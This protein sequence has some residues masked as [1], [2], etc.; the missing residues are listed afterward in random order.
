MGPGPPPS[1]G[2]SPPDNQMWVTE[3]LQRAAHTQCMALIFCEYT[4]ELAEDPGKAQWAGKA[5]WSGKA[6]EFGHYGA[7]YPRWQ[8]LHPGLQDTGLVSESHLLGVCS[9][10]AALRM[11]PHRPGP[12]RA[13]GSAGELGTLSAGHRRYQVRALCGKSP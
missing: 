3:V 10:Q 2:F 1:L 4:S 11:C 8:C 9:L 6:R 7:Q 12:D 5:Q 13:V